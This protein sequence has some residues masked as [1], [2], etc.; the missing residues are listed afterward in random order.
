MLQGNARRLW[1]GIKSITNYRRDVNR[2][3]V[4]GSFLPNFDSLPPTPQRHPPKGPLRLDG[5]KL[6]GTRASSQ[7]SQACNSH[8]K[9]AVQSVQTPLMSTPH[10]K[11]PT[12][13]VTVFSTLL[14]SKKKPKNTHT[15]LLFLDYS[16]HFQVTRPVKRLNWQTWALG[17]PSPSGN[18]ILEFHTD[19]P[20]RVMID[21]SP[22]T[23]T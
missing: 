14:T 16:S 11:H 18:Y 20:D 6:L 4:Q 1:Q 7:G 23:H 22:K 8:H 17:V 10:R 5:T 13:L 2:A 12:H 3:V 19:R 9:A 21:F 15:R